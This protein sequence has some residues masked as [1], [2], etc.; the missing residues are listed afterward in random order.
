[1]KFGLFSVDDAEATELVSGDIEAPGPEAFGQIEHILADRK[2]AAPTAIGHRIVHGGFQLREHCLIDDHTVALLEQASAF[3]PI[4][5][6]ASLALIRLA[7]EHFG[8]LPQV[9][10]FDTVFH[11]DLPEVAYVL[12]IPREY[13]AAGI[14]RYGFHGLSCE[15][16]VRHLA[17]DVP[18]RLIVAH[19]GNGSSVTAIRDG[20]SIDTSMGLTPSGGVIMA[21]RSGDLD[22]GVLLYLLREKHI[23]AAELAEMIDFRSGLL[24]ISDI[25]G[26][27]RRLHEAAPTNA[28]A[29]LAIGMFCYSVR[30]QIAGMIAALGGI[31]LLVFTGGVGENDDAVRATICAGLDWVDGL[32]V[33]VIESRE[34]AMIAAHTRAIVGGKRPKPS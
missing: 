6:P 23:D 17:G 32:A 24:G 15:S 28:D 5:D 21:S 16:V 19:L 7:R 13:R 4:H 2:C 25:S 18:A 14:R 3:A 29:R 30:K 33:D 10:C 20:R 22:P 26:D 34:D 12:P 1:M 31:D 27:M 8:A 11:A 9:A